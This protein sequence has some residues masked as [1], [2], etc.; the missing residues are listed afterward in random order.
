M[1][2]QQRKKAMCNN[3]MMMN[4]GMMMRG[5]RRFGGGCGMGM[6]GNNCQVVNIN[7]NEYNQT[8]V[9]GNFHNPGNF[10]YGDGSAEHNNYEQDEEYEDDQFQDDYQDQYEDQYQD[11]Y[12]DQY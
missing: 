8:Q 9:Q 6:M 10:G 11:Q 2:N 5:R 7:A 3:A 4:R 12:E 1:G